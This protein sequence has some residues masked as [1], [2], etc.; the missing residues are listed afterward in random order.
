ME[1]LGQPIEKLPLVDLP[2]SLDEIPRDQQ[3]LGGVIRGCVP[4]P[5]PSRWKFLQHLPWDLV[6][7]LPLPRHAQRVPGRV[8]QDPRPNVLRGGSDPS[9]EGSVW[10][11][12]LTASDQVATAWSWLASAVVVLLRQQARANSRSCTS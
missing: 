5:V 2:L 4:G 9:W 3:Q 11:E 6:R 7:R 10:H 12:G 8:R 1:R